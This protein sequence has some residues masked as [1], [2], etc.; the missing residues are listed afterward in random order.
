[1]YDKIAVSVCLP[2]FNGAKYLEQAI[3][4]VLDQ[5]FQ[6]FE[7]LISDDGSTDDSWSIVERYAKQD[8][9]ISAWK[10]SK[11]LGLFGN[12]NECL[13]RAKGTYIK[14]FA[15]DDLIEKNCLSRMM[16]I[17]N[18]HRDVSLVTSARN[19]IDGQGNLLSLERQFDTDTKL[20]ANETIKGNMATFVNWI[21]EPCTVMFRNA[22]SGQGFD[23]N[24][25]LYGDVEYWFRVLGKSDLY[26]IS[27]ALSSFRR[28]LGS[29]SFRALEDLS[30]WTDILM[31]A[32]TYGNELADS[33]GQTTSLNELVYRK[34][35]FWVSK[36]RK[37]QLRCDYNSIET[38]ADA[39]SWQLDLS[40]DKLL[41]MLRLC[42]TSFI[43][44]S[45]ELAE[46]KEQAASEKTVLE[47][48]LKQAREKVKLLEENQLILQKQLDATKQSLHAVQSRITYRVAGR[49]TDALLRIR[50]LKKLFSNTNQISTAGKE[51]GGTAASRVDTR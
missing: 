29:E 7:L 4:C 26:Y 11:Q 27:D 39:K 35:L 16:Q 20:T 40:S 12:Y 46:A 37:F 17:F 24:Y 5:D 21:G 36:I 33:N 43:R 28:H 8:A 9:R 25:R 41:K 18:E 23:E 45:I 10:T 44:C 49:V 6:N 47:E 38:G 42:T 3:N 13:R 48:E 30:F 22:S 34:G 51:N 31:L 14:P 50:L 1:M 15:Q 19:I 32:S 2:I